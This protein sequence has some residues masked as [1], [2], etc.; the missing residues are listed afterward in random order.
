MCPKSKPDQSVPSSSIDERAE[1]SEEERQNAANAFGKRRTIT[2]SGAFPKSTPKG[3]PRAPSGHP[4]RQVTDESQERGP[5]TRSTSA[6]EEV[7]L[8]G[9]ETK[10]ASRYVFVAPRRGKKK[11]SSSNDG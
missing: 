8:I 6:R 3:D 11:P 1:L 4:V 7:V 2:K 5:A 9:V 10:K